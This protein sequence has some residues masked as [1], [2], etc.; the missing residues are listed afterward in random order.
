MMKVNGIAVFVGRIRSAL[1]G[2]ET[3]GGYASQGYAALHPGLF[4]ALPPGALLSLST[5]DAEELLMLSADGTG[6]ESVGRFA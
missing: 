4:S 1:R 2:G 6:R 3:F 5:C